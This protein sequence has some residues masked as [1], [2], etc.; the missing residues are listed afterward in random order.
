VFSG[1]SKEI[2]FSRSGVTRAATEVTVK[3]LP[4]RYPIGLALALVAALSAGAPGTIPAEQATRN[5]ARGAGPQKA[6]TF[7]RLAEAVKPAVIN[8][9]AE[10]DGGG[11]SPVEGLF[12]AGPDRRQRRGR[13]SGV[14]I[15]PRGLALANAQVVGGASLVEVTM[16]DGT[17]YVARVV[18]TDAKTD[19]AVIQL[20]ADGRTLPFLP[21]GDSD[22]VRLG[23]WVIAVGSPFGL[24]A[25]VTSGVVSATA[26]AAGAGPYDHFLQTD[27]AINPG[28]SGGPLVNMRGE[29]IGINTAIVRGSFGIG[30]AIPAN[31]A[32][33]ISSELAARATWLTRQVPTHG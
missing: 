23:D 16:L 11:R 5:I 4:S 33:R 31:I 26:G 13:G 20:Q 29:V 8:V 19:L 32:R 9:N 6:G 22:A 3:T 28:S 12:G 10:G 15:D 7:A 1:P 21:L 14:I 27:A 17:T 25:T 18:G 2:L 24:Q 30:F